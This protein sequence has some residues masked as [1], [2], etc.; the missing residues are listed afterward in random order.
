MNVDARKS[1]AM[2]NNH[3]PTAQSTA[4]VSLAGLWSV[5]LFALTGT[6]LALEW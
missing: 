4:M 1:S 6:D 3:V 5:F 2:E